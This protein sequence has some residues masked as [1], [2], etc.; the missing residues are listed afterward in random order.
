[1][2]RRGA[3]VDS[4]GKEW[5]SMVYEKMTCSICGEL[6]NFDDDDTRNAVITAPDYRFNDRDRTVYYRCSK[7]ECIVE[8]YNRYQY[9]RG[10]DYTRVF[11]E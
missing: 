10:Y 6:I 9:T 7:E 5:K 11:M 8:A 4:D 2:Q 3:I 1:M